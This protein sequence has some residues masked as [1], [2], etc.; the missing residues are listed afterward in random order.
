ELAP[1]ARER[2]IAAALA[3]L[4][5]HAAAL[6]A[7]AHERAQALLAD[8]RRVRDAARA[9]G[10]YQVRALLPLDVIATYVLLPVSP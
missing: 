3:A 4:P 6:Q 1:A 2:F 10:D 8:H 7:L 9:R 5:E